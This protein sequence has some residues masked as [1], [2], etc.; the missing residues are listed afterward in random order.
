VKI[1]TRGSERELNG[2]LGGGDGWGGVVERR[3]VRKGSGKNMDRKFKMLLR[4]NCNVENTLGLTGGARRQPEETNFCSA[5][6]A[7]Q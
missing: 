6:V 5:L 2:G 3:R 4:R 1:D 7:G